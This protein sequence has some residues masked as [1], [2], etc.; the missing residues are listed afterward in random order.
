[1]KRGTHYH[2]ITKM[3]SVNICLSSDSNYEPH[4]WVTLYSLIS[5]AK[6]NRSYQIYILDGGIQNK[7]NFYNLVATD[8]RFSIEFIDMTSQFSNAFESRH[9]SKAAYYRLAIFNLF[10]ELNKIIYLDADSLVLSDIAE[11]Y[12]IN[13]ADKKI[14]GVRDSIT[15]EKPWRE[16][17]ISYKY[18]SGKA[19]NYFEDYLHFSSK[20]LNKYFSSGVL[21][22]NLS[23]INLE[24][25]KK[26]LEN[27]MRAEYFCHDQDVLNLL[28]DEKETL[29]IGREWNY[30]NSG[31]ILKENDFVIEDER[32]NY[33]NEMKPKVVSYVLKPW[34]KEYKN[35]P[36]GKEYWEILSYSPY[37]NMVRE[38]MKKNT[39]VSRFLQLS[40]I[41]K[42][43]FL[44]S[45]NAIKKY[46]E[47]VRSIFR[48]R[49]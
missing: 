1:M 37:F 28:F 22:F 16:K 47:I 12:D 41:E 25:K 48:E 4:L 19:I 49:N 43:R 44:T 40:L 46:G 36:Y 45:K 27:L 11:L 34:L 21:I 32:E 3:A 35:S 7:Q 10:S 20:K 13:M 42:I 29:L 18:Y 39:K 14:A 38:S 6:S 24:Q 2:N 9:V 26:E 30:F 15:Y 8:K 23:K 33:L 17:Y 5:S 31:P